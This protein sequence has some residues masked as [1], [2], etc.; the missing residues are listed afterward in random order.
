L[1][2]GGTVFLWLFESCSQNP[3]ADRG[4]LAAFFQSVTARTAG[5]NTVD[6][7]ALSDG[8]KLV[9]I[10][11]MFHR[12]ARPAPGAGGIKTTSAFD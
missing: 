8:S 3:S 11:L 12:P 5:F 1:I 2:A 6:I 7:A 9:L 10:L 4:I